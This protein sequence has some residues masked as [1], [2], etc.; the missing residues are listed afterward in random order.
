MK[1][2]KIENSLNVRMPSRM[3][4]GSYSAI[5]AVRL[6]T[7][8]AHETFYALLPDSA[9]NAAITTLLKDQWG[10]SIF[11]D[12]TFNIDEAPDQATLDIFNKP[13]AW[14]STFDRAA[15]LS[16]TNVR[17]LSI[18]NVLDCNYVR[19]DVSDTAMTISI[20]PADSTKTPE[21][22]TQLLGLVFK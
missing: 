1:V 3:L 14:S 21:E 4:L 9:D 7:D 12:M 17:S 18:F 11:N 5:S 16:I 20:D 10:I 2:L 8:S 19:A 22:I 13:T 6:K 15:N